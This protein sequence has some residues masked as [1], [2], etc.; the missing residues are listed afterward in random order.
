M[1]SFASSAEILEQTQREKSCLSHLFSRIE[2]LVQ[3]AVL[4]TAKQNG[5]ELFFGKVCSPTTVQGL[6]AKLQ[7]GGQIVLSRN[8]QFNFRT[9]AIER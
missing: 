4:R 2:Q 8:W 5:R 6:V 3:R 1:S 7:R 9:E